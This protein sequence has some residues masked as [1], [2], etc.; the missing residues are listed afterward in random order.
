M[1]WKNNTALALSD[2]GDSVRRWLLW[3]GLGWHDIR[4]RYRRTTLGPIWL[5]IVTAVSVTSLG[6]VYGILFK[7]R[8]VLIL[9]YVTAEL[10]I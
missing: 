1:S 4:G 5:V 9:P 3:G 2:L 7:S 8:L 6:V 10:I